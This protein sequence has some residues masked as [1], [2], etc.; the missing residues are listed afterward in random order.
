MRQLFICLSIVSIKVIVIAGDNKTRPEFCKTVNFD[1]VFYM[2]RN[3]TFKSGQ[4]YW[5]L[6]LTVQRM[7]PYVPESQVQPITS[8]F[9][10]RVPDCLQNKDCDQMIKA[11]DVLFVR[12][13]DA[14]TDAE[15]TLVSLVGNDNRMTPMAA[16]DLPWALTNP[17]VI[18]PPDFVWKPKEPKPS[19]YFPGLNFVFY[20][21]KANNYSELHYT[22]IDSN[23]WYKTTRKNRLMPGITF[24]GM[25]HTYGNDISLMIALRPNTVFAIGHED[26]DPNR[27]SKLFFLKNDFTF[28]YEVSFVKLF[29]L[30]ADVRLTFLNHSRRI[31]N[32]FSFAVNTKS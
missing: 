20:I 12:I 21:T 31:C 28:E 27:E 15:S 18:W 14:K 1:A 29:V 2:G 8:L 10:D 17:H 6:D 23:D 30:N 4:W 26:R 25:F 32:E 19:L 3:L 9:I 7:M 22:A 11:L 13:V 16:G 24:V 5:Q